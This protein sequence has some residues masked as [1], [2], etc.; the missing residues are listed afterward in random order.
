MDYV[1]LRCVAEYGDIVEVGKGEFPFR[2]VPDLV[3]GT[4]ESAGCAAESK[5]HAYEAM[6][7]IKGW[8]W[9]FIFVCNTKLDLLIFVISVWRQIDGYFSMQV[10]AFFLVWYQVRV[11]RTHCVKITKDDAISD[12]SVFFGN[13]YYRW[14]TLYLCGLD[15]VLDEHHI[16]LILSKV[17]CFW[18]SLKRFHLYSHSVRLW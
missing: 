12:S 3:H 1:F 17:V 14:G 2:A 8:E 11:P 10:Y 18:T 5:W 15:G 9:C 7:T 16:N 13:K 4:L 6:G